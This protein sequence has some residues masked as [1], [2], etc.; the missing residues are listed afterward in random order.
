MI[1]TGT[2]K[3]F[4]GYMQEYIGEKIL[5]LQELETLINKGKK[6]RNLLWLQDN[7]LN[8]IVNLNTA[9]KFASATN[10]RETGIIYLARTC[11]HSRVKQ[12]FDDKYEIVSGGLSVNAIV[13]PEFDL[14]LQCDYCIAFCCWRAVSSLKLFLH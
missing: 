7:N 2:N 6:S 3:F 1:L 13:M 4:T 8:L 12:I 10:N 11:A 9:V 5:I 14:A